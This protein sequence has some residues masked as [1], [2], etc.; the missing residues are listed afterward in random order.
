[1]EE[2]IHFSF[3]IRKNI[4]LSSGSLFTL[5]IDHNIYFTSNDYVLVLYLNK[6]TNQNCSCIF[7]TFKWF[8]LIDRVKSGKQ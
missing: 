8:I 7:L 1:M 4:K 3:L 5:Q 2:S 6:L